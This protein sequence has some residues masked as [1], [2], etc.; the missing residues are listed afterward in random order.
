LSKKIP[1]PRIPERSGPEYPISQRTNF[2]FLLKSIFENDP[3]GQ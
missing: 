2:G 3:F 1:V